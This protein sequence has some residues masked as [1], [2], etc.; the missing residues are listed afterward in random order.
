M[1]DVTTN[2]SA[3]ADT[4]TNTAAAASTAATKPWFEGKATPEDIG[5]VELRKL[6]A[7][8]PIAGKFAWLVDRRPSIR[9]G[10]EAGHRSV[11]QHHDRWVIKIDQK[12]YLRSR[13][14]WFWMT[15][16]WPSLHIDHADGNT[17]NDRWANLREATRSQ[18]LANAAKPKNSRAPFKGVCRKH[19]R[20]QAQ[21]GHEGR[22]IYLG[23]FDSAA[24]AQAAYMSAAQKFYGE[25][26]RMS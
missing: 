17:L 24:E 2:T 20:Y 7:Y 25:F 5:H 16:T 19:G 10:D 3:S 12:P 14:A 9:A 4:A 22:K 6:L 11:R 13:L 23:L 15:G 26:A 18:N 1:T 21:I 8:D